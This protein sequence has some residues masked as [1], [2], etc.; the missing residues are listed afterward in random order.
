MEFSPEVLFWLGS[1]LVKRTRAPS[2]IN[3][4]Q[5]LIEALEALRLAKYLIALVVVF[6]FLMYD[7]GKLVAQFTRITSVDLLEALTYSREV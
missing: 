7:I 1:S 2:Q 4:I 6:T 3:P 5:S